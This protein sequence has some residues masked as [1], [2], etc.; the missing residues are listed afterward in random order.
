MSESTEV[1]EPTMADR[2]QLPLSFDAEK[3]IAEV[4]ALNLHDYVYY[5]VLPLRGPAHEIDSSLPP[6]PPAEDYADGTW[7]DWLNS[8]VL[9]SCPELLKVLEYFQEHTRVTLVRLLR[10]APDSVVREH[11]D[12]TLGLDIWKS[13]IRLTIP[14]QINEGVEFY[15]NGTTVPMQPGE[16]WYLRLTDPHSVVNAG[17]TDRINLTIDM[18]PNEWVRALVAGT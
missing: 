9:K 18:E 15:L 12:P 14:I 8:S 17:T 16:C 5:D 10:L 1:S 4:Q 6:P 13:V 7:T 3:M 2:I 11:T